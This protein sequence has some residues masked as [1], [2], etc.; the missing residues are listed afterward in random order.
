MRERLKRAVAAG[1]GREEAVEI[2]G[3]LL[4]KEVR[5]FK[6]E[7]QRA[8]KHAQEFAKNA[9]LADALLKGAGTRAD[10]M[11]LIEHAMIRTARDIASKGLDESRMPKIAQE[12]YKCVELHKG[13][14]HL[15]RIPLKFV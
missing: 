14:T 1:A 13:G 8:M 9:H 2:I 12:I 3:E 7:P 10:A 15:K 11:H 5:E 4:E 6:K